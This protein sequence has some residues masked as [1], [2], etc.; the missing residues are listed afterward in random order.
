M[1]VVGLA[2]TPAVPWGMANHPDPEPASGRKRRAHTPPADLPSIRFQHSAKLRERTLEVLQKVE[3]AEDATDHREDLADLIVE[4]THCGLDT[5]FMEPL[6]LA[7]AG[8]IV[9]QS[10][11]LGMA[12]AKQ[13]MGSVIR[14]IIGRME[15]PQLLSI[16]GSIR[17]FMG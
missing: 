5:F 16:C 8:F 15:G 11:N 14:N 12:G 9:Q 2:R 6:K 17:G 13:M 1:F 3:D 7:K 10:A 4:L